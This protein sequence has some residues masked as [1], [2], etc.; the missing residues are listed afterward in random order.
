MC[1]GTQHFFFWVSQCALSRLA[2]SAGKRRKIALATT[3]HLPHRLLAKALA[4]MD[5]EECTTNHRRRL[6]EE[7]ENAL[8][9]TTP[10][11]PLVQTRSIAKDTTGEHYT[12]HH[13]NPFAL[14]W[15]LCNLSPQFAH[16]MK[17]CYESTAPVRRKLALYNDETTPGNQKRPDNSRQLQA[18]YF[19]LL[20]SPHWYRKRPQG[21]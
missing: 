7:I 1:S 6:H 4:A 15:T 16:F 3:P 12:W 14:M 20:I 9:Q 8:D 5:G 10:Y 17:R 13:T 19:T 11:G 2:I 18:I 21:W